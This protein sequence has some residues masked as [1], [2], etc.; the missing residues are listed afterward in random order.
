MSPG[1]QKAMTSII[2]KGKN[3][4]VSITELIS[5]CVDAC[6]RGCQV[7]RSV[8]EKRKREVTEALPAKPKKGVCDVHVMDVLVWNHRT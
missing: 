8:D 7:I 3:E 5:T 2:N 1:K 4:N 6:S